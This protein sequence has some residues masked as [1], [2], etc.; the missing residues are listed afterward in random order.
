M[1]L[2]CKGTGVH[3]LKSWY[4]LKCEKSDLAVFLTKAYF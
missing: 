3:E 4:V 1:I 2:T